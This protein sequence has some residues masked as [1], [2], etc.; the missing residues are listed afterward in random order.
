MADLS[1]SGRSVRMPTTAPE[2]S[3]AIT[4]FAELRTRACQ[5]GPKRVGVVL[6][7]DDVALTAASDAL[8]LGIAF[9]VLIGDKA[10]IRA[11]AESLGLRELAHRAEFVSSPHA[12]QTA[13]GL[14]R[15]GCIDIVMKGHLRTDELLHPILDKQNGLRT[16][17]LLCDI[18]ICEYPEPGSPRL[19]GMSDGGINV[20]PTLLQKR[21]IILAAIDVLHA[22]GNPRPKI[23]V[24]SALEVVIDAI[25]STQD[26]HALSQMALTGAFGDAQ[27][28]GPLALDNALF[29]WAARAKGITHPVAGHADFLVMPNIEAGNMLAKSV[30]FLARWRFAHVVAGAA[31][32]ILIPSRV[33]R[34]EDKV[35][36][37]ALGVLYAS[38]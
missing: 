26:A 29:E 2:L 14:A 12:A 30:I 4:N 20:A 35:N 31:V 6:A 27:V 22:L 11:H 17:A 10:R 19:I 16:G 7:D 24:M 21:E 8:L 13:V 25:P 32:P 1:H 15:E 28:Y 38:R 37:I 9:P 36:S 23:A 3:T 33:E 34:A 5:A 18:A